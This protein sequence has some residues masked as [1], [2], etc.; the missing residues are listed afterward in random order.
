MGRLPT[1]LY[2]NVLKGTGFRVCVS[3]NIYVENQCDCR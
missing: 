2:E 3:T 1:Q